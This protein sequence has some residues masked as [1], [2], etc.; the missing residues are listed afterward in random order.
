MIGRAIELHVDVQV[1]FKETD[2]LKDQVL[3][4][5]F[6]AGGLSEVPQDGFR[7]A[8]FSNMVASELGMFGLRPEA[9]PFLQT[10]RKTCPGG[11][12]V[13]RPPWTGPFVSPSRPA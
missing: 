4:N 10:Q 13:S 5:G 3:L 12:A 9:R 6:A 11:I 1:T 8:S 2:F 7:S